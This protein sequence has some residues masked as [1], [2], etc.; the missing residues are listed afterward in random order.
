MAQVPPRTAAATPAV[1]RVVI[2]EPKD[3]W[4]DDFGRTEADLRRALGP[5]ALRVDHIGSTSVPDLGAKDVIDVQVTVAAPGDLDEALGLL[6]AAGWDPRRPTTDHRFPGGPA[7]ARQWAKRM[8]R[9]R[10]GERRANIHL[11]VDGHANQRYALLFRDYLAVH[12]DVARAYLSFKQ[13]AAHLCRDDLDT[14]SDVK[15]PVCD[16]IY[17]LA[18]RWAAATNWHPGRGD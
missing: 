3:S 4:S 2:A 10:P 9:E 14:Y 8:C 16:V 7:D 11:R 17:L 6:V 1:D 13:R 18:E 12:P 5:L 15:D